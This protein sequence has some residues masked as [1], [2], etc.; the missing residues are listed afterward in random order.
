MKNITRACFLM[1]FIAGSA[2][3]QVPEKM[4]YQAVIRNSS[5]TLL[6]NQFVGMQISVLQ[7][8]PSGSAVYIETQNATSNANGLVSI[9][10]GEGTVISGVFSG[11]D[12]ANGPYFIK[13]ETDP[14]GGTNYTIIGTS[15]LMS[16]PYA[17]YAKTAG[18]SMPGPQGAIGATGAE[19]QQGIIGA[20]GATGAEGPQGIIGATG[21]DGQQGIMGA[22]GAD[23]QQGIIGATGADGQ[24]GATGVAGANGQQGATGVTGADGTQGIIGATGA[25][26]LQGVMGMTGN[27][28]AQGLLGVTGAQGLQG[29]I[30][31]TGNQGLQ[32]STGSTGA[33]G[34]QGAAGIKGTTGSTG[35]QGLQGLI[36]ATGTTGA[37]GII[38]STGAQGLQGITGNTGAQGIQGI[39][40]I[41]GTTGSTGPQGL[42]GAIGA[43]GAQGLQGIIGTT[44]AQGLQ[45]II[46]TT[47][48]SGQQGAIG[49]TGA[50]GLQGATGNTGAQGLQGLV[51][52]TGPGVPAGVNSGNMIVYDGTNWVAKTLTLGTTGSSVPFN[53]MQPYTVVNFCIA[54]N[55]I[56]PSRNGVEPYIGEIEMFGFDFNPV[57]WYYCNGQ[58]LSISANAA[59]FSLL[60]TQ[61]GGSGVTTFGLPDLRGRV[62]MHQFQGP[63]LSTRTMG[64]LG[65]TENTT[66]LI[67][68]LPAHSHNVVFTAP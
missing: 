60:G 18:N 38:G 44:G 40:G 10:I 36:G 12:W 52:A 9:E 58:L 61:F 63:G 11:I 7:G 41:K 25:Q 6:T 24:Q 20:T 16:V 14:A 8:A 21:A 5:N 1:V 56:Y 39:A 15:Q 54:A 64:E 49:V 51:G 27:T 43:T 37:A 19:G 4:S 29:L 55:G 67:N 3:A 23:G 66:L 65:G 2:M 46:G 48:A 22:T 28:G 31:F 32:G 45:G 33:Q 13:I 62:P 42:Q 59:L 34:I 53:N 57:D 35:T 26:G 30:G 68:N 47:G 50:Q 17:L